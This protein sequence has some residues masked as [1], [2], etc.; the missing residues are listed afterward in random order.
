MMGNSDC[1]RRN[2]ISFLTIFFWDSWGN[3]LLDLSIDLVDHAFK[4]IRKTIV[5]KAYLVWLFSFITIAANASVYYVS[6]KGSD[7]ANGTSTTTPWLSINKVNGFTFKPGDQILFNRGDTFYGAITVNQSGAAGSP[8]IYGA[9]GSGAAPIITGFTNITT[10]VND[11]SSIYEYTCSACQPSLN[12]LTVDDTVQPMGRW[13]RISDPNEGYLVVSSHNANSSITSTQISGSSTY[14]GGELV[15]RKMQYVLDRARITAQT[16]TTVTYNP[17]P[18][19]IFTPTNLFGFFFQNHVNTLKKTG[20]W[21][22]DS[23][24]K[25]IKIYGAP[26]NVKASTLSNLVNITNKSYVNFNSLSFKGSNSNI[27]NIV[28]SKFIQINA[29][30]ISYAGIDAICITS[31]VSNNITVYDCTIS[32]SNNNAI[33][34][35][36]SPNLTISNDY[37]SNT[38]AIRG[39]GQS[40]GMGYI[41]INDVGAKSYVWHNQI[42]NTGYHGLRFQGDSVVIKNN[43]ITGFAKTLNDAAG[44]Y[45]YGDQTS[46]GRIIR[47]NIVING[48]G[49]RYG[50]DADLTNPY[51]YNVHGIYLDG[52]SKNVIV[53]SNTVSNCSFDGLEL[54]GSVNVQVLHN[55]LYNNNAFQ[56]D[57]GDRFTPN[58]IFKDNLLFSARPDQGILYIDFTAGGSYSTMGTFD[59]N[60]YCRPIY[61]PTG[62]NTRGY[63]HG[64]NWA[65]P[66]SD[67]GI[68]YYHPTNHFYS[69]DTWKS[70]SGQD[71]HTQKTPV[72]ITQPK[73]PL[74]SATDTA[75]LFEYNASPFPRT[76]SLGNNKYI[77][78]RNT[79]YSGTV[80]LGQYASIILIY[81]GPLN[82]VDAIDSSSQLIATD[83]QQTPKE[84]ILA[85][86][87]PARNSL[88]L[89]I[90]SE[91]VGKARINIYDMS[92]R[93]IQL[94]EASKDLEYLEKALN[95]SGLAS[96]LYT[97]EVLIGYN[98]RMVTKFIKQ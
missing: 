52:G 83:D 51:A 66:Y 78:V 87:N 58:I 72:S 21:C 63:S 55:T 42:Y 94:I 38:G 23:L 73:E 88:T 19:A 44:I 27:F 80:T 39:A 9:Y 20:D 18:N 96:G 70:L 81:S 25:K 54:S 33:E 49:D 57:L 93:A 43:L 32:N 5:K 41:A 46:F 68:V 75:V 97:V 1:L 65:Y 89:Q 47:G 36:G 77:D 15:I 3:S 7:A 2:K 35:N 26:P 56:M 8:I 31:S 98:K 12:M 24:T 4:S 91:S 6:A 50:M 37:I 59:S 28:T 45:S 74:S 10:W 60:Y 71:I 95:I 61:E 90:I 40:G 48:F 67:G 34:A 86:P 79:I 64:T 62:I 82:K 84:R 85:Y 11:G 22:Y 14:V 13:P 53:D 76:I 16:S 92:G 17:F 30:T 69:L 29:S